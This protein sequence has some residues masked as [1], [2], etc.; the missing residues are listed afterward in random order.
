MSFYVRE[1]MSVGPIKFNLSKSGVGASIGVEGF[2]LG[3]GP[4]GGYVHVGKSPVRYRKYKQLDSSESEPESESDSNQGG[5]A[6][7]SYKN[8][9]ELDEGELDEGEFEDLESADASSLVETEPEGIVEEINE[10]KGRW[11]FWPL[12]ALLTVCSVALSIIVAV[13]GAVVTVFIYQ[14]D[15]VRKTVALFYDFEEDTKDRYRQACD[16]FEFAV[17]SKEILFAEVEFGTPGSVRTNIPI[18]SISTDDRSLY[19]FPDLIL[20]EDGNKVSKF[21]YRKLDL[22]SSGK[23][24][25]ESKSHPSDAKLIDSEWKHSNKD[26]SRDKRYNDN[27]KIYATQ[28]EV[29]KVKSSESGFGNFEVAFSK[30]GSFSKMTDMLSKLPLNVGEQDV[31]YNE[32]GGI[33]SQLIDVGNANSEKENLT[34]EGM[35]QE[36]LEV[37]VKTFQTLSDSEQKRIVKKVAKESRGTANFLERIRR[38]QERS[39]KIR[40]ITDNIKDKFSGGENEEGKNKEKSIKEKYEVGN[41]NDIE[42]AVE[43]FRRMTQEEREEVIREV[44]NSEVYR[45]VSTMLEEGKK[46]KNIVDEIKSVAGG[47]E[48][49]SGSSSQPYEAASLDVQIQKSLH[50]IPNRQSAEWV[51]EVVLEES[52]IHEEIAARRVANAAGAGRMGSRIQEA[53]DE[54]I[55]Y[56]AQKGWVRKKRHLL[57]DPNQEDVPVRDRSGL[58]GQ[59]RDIEYVP[60]PEIAEA[61]EQIAGTSSG[62]GK[63]ELIQQVAHQLGFKRA[64]SKIQERIRSIISTMLEENM[65]ERENG[66]LLAAE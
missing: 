11:R 32:L 40:R 31:N 6:G 33:A 20:V 7:Q 22:S 41:I 27:Y 49:A 59:D 57:F 14:R 15:K 38:M 39:E 16:S 45:K 21:S 10:A 28:Y 50:E 63:E 54:A 9:G 19:F 52:P 3:A 58:E 42:D 26:G 13:I 5:D 23:L 8:E 36:D 25:K 48:E 30:K 2:R 44:D 12:A 43:L 34:N 65:L 55:Q 29:L 46:T 35:D 37:L 60:G 4:K 17:G 66:H 51:K 62:I 1:G 18:P 56:A 64:G 61:A 53:L 47:Q 24:R